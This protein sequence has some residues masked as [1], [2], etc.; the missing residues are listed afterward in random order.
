MRRGILEIL[1][2]FGLV[3]LGFAFQR[4]SEF[5]VTGG[6]QRRGK[7]GGIGRSSEESSYGGFVLSTS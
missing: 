1:D 7:G 6:R 2:I 5:W 4:Y 3:R